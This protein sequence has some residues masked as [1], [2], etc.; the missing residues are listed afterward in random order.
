MARNHIL[1]ALQN[2][3][4]IDVKTKQSVSVFSSRKI[5]YLKL[6]VSFHF[7]NTNY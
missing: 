2:A 1:C 3:I 7:F 6:H 4:N 5:Q